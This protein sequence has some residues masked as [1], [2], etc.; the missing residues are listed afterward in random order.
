MIT[1]RYHLVSIVAVFL[2]LAIG[3]V[4]GYG[5]LSQ[6]TVE[7]LQSRIDTV[8]ANADA[9][10]AENDQLRAENDQLRAAG[11]AMSEFAATDRLSGVPVVVL[12]VRDVAEESVTRVVELARRGGASAPGILWLESRWGLPERADVDALATAVGTSESGRGAVR[13]DAWRELTARLALGPSTI[14][15]VLQGLVNGDFVTFDSVD[16][17]SEDLAEIGGPGTRVVLADGVRAETAPRHPAPPIARAARFVSLPLVVAE[18][19]TADGAERG[20]RVVFIRDAEELASLFATVDDLER[21]DG[22]IAVVLALADLGRGTVGH[23]GIGPE[24][25]ALLPAWWQP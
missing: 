3:V 1:F 21:V 11:D 8:E 2:A 24:A 13:D 16:G 15:D 12:A 14:D 4:M 22:Q 23:Y 7:G 20:T 18:E 17:P 5:V 10:R 6:P 25:D 19:F 9:Q